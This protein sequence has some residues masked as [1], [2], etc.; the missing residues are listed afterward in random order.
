MVLLNRL[1]NNNTTMTKICTKCKQEKSLDCFG[2]E[3]KGKNGLKSRCKKCNYKYQRE[4]SKTKNGLMSRMYSN[5]KKRCKLE[6]GYKHR[7]VSFTRSEFYHFIK[8]SAF[9]EIYTNWVKSGYTHKL[10]PS[11]DRIDNNSG[12]SI[13]NIQI[14][15]LSDNVKKDSFVKKHGIHPGSKLSRN[16]VSEIRRIYKTGLYTQKEVGTKYGVGQDTVSLI[17]NM[18]QWK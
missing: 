13:N 11:V 8:T 2:K 14:I 16:D 3:K 12:Y 6:N 4:F 15:T 18:K 9:N 1:K 10:V 17:V 7:C 5:M